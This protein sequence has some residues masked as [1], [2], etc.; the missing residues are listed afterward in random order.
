LLKKELAKTKELQN[1]LS[2]SNDELKN[3]YEKDITNFNQQ[4]DQ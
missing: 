4:K 3:K 1:S 2:K